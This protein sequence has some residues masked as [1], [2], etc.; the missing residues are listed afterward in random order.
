M[1]EF[2]F[3]SR[4]FM[5]FFCSYFH[6][7]L[8]FWISNH[9]SMNDQIFNSIKAINNF[10]HFHRIELFCQEKLNH[11]KKKWRKNLSTNTSIVFL[12]ITLHVITNSTSKLFNYQVLLI[13]GII[14]Y[15]K[16]LYNFIYRVF[17]VILWWQKTLHW[18]FIWRLCSNC[19]IDVLSDLIFFYSATF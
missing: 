15:C 18:K 8:T 17:S 1:K 4:I 9:Q 11:K 6:T 7:L 5:D 14:H 16:Y 10:T 19:F 13:N 2:F 3:T 12:K